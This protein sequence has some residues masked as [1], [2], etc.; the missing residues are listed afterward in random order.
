M[1]SS[2]ATSGEYLFDNIVEYIKRDYDMICTE[3]NSK[4]YH[5]HSS[6]SRIVGFEVSVSK[7][8]FLFRFLN[9]GKS[10]INFKYLENT[11]SEA[12]LFELDP[13][14]DKSSQ[15]DQPPL[16][17]SF[18]GR[19]LSVD[20]LQLLADKKSADCNDFVRKLK[21]YSGPG[22]EEYIVDTM[23]GMHYQGSD[24]LNSD[25]QKIEY[26]VMYDKNVIQKI[27]IKE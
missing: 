20:T 13:A 19:Q 10:F 4:K 1:S 17:K 2:F 21:N 23:S 27:Q 3:K 18:F 25:G 7:P 8:F 15:H 9:K 12:K 6:T 5:C 24:C 22:D 26:R 16:I 11:N 14:N